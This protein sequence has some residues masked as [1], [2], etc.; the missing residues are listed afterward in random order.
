MVDVIFHVDA[1]FQRGMGHLFRTLSLAKVFT[2]RR[3]KG[4]ILFFGRLSEESCRILTN[5]SY[6]CVAISKDSDRNDTLRHLLQTENTGLIINDVLDASEATLKLERENAERIICL[7]DTKYGFQ[8]AHAV[9]NPIVFLKATPLTHQNPCRYY[10]G[11]SYMV[12]DSRYGEIK[13]SQD[14]WNCRGKRLLIT[15]GELTPGTSPQKLFALSLPFLN[16]KVFISVSQSA[17]VS[18]KEPY[19]STGFR[20][21]PMVRLQFTLILL[22]WVTLCMNMTSLSVEAEL[23]SMKALPS[24]DQYLQLLMNSMKCRALISS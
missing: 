24:A 5:H 16:V 12:L 14:T 9:I 3:M 19:S 21:S 1:N 8:Y 2:D 18:Q 23:P 10:P 11:P 13:A 22:G 17:L 20:S 7:D 4:R 15:M 6:Q